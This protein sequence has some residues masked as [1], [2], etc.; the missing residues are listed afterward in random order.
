MKEKKSEK[1][2][3]AQARM[4]AVEAASKG[5]A[6]RVVV[7]KWPDSEAD[8]QNEAMQR[9]IKNRIARTDA[10]FYPEIDL[11]QAG[12]REPDRRF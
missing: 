8:F 6:A 4:E 7:I 2:L 1:E 3:A 12:R 9:N 5:Q 11:Y 10:K